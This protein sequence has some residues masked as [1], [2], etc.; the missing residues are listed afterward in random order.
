M[1]V[2]R[3]LEDEEMNRGIGLF[4][5]GLS[6]RQVACH[7]GVLQNVIG[8][9]RQH[10]QTPEKCHSRHGGS[11]IMFTTQAQDRFIVVQA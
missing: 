4:E 11:F 2:E 10:Y 5:A 9:I 3:H 8:M 6:Q 1:Q 7:L